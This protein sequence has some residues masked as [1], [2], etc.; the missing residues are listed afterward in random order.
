MK[1]YFIFLL[2][3]KKLKILTNLNSRTTTK[4]YLFLIKNSKH[5]NQEKC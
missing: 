4:F 1:I 5:F 2:Y 3:N